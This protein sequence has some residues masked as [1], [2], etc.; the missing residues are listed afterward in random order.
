MDNGCGLIPEKP[1]IHCSVVCLYVS[2]ATCE[3][4]PGGGG[5]SHMV[6]L[7]CLLLVQQPHLNKLGSGL[8]QTVWSAGQSHCTLIRALGLVLVAPEAGPPPWRA[9]RR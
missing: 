4:P 5:G 9:A 7:R 1:R 2:L 6:C 3:V 8:S